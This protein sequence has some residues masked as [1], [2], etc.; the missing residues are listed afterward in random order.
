MR[1]IVI[2]ACGVFAY[3]TFQVSFLYLFAFMAGIVVSKTLDSGRA[4]PLAPAIAVNT[5]LL[6]MFG[7]QHGVMAR[8]TFKSRLTKC[9][10]EPLERSVYVIEDDASV[11]RV[12]ERLLKSAN[13]AVRTRT[14]GPG[15]YD[16]G[17]TTKVQLVAL[18]ARPSPLTSAS[19]TPS[20]P[21]DEPSIVCRRQGSLAADLVP[22]IHSSRAKQ[23]RRNMSAS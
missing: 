4:G 8:D 1:R 9:V 10:P 22:W 17:P 14:I 16:Q 21:S 20:A 2:L 15:S 19:R 18:S 11:R 5:L 6:A 3:L 23:A 13:L 12:R 7:V